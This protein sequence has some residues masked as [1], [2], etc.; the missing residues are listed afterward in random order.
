MRNSNY[1]WL[2]ASWL[3]F[4]LN[5]IA[6]RSNYYRLSAY[7]TQFA[8]DFIDIHNSFGIIIITYISEQNGVCFV[9]LYCWASNS[10]HFFVRFFS[11]VSCPLFWRMK[12]APSSRPNTQRKRG[13]TP[14]LESLSL[15]RPSLTNTVAS[16]SQHLGYSSWWVPPSLLNMFLCTHW[17][18]I[19]FKVHFPFLCVL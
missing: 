8:K 19:V 2:K 14:Y 12:Y 11:C 18:P 9:F 17:L 1:C 16:S 5:N 7:V 6:C 15:T 4:K 13:W 3:S 10:R